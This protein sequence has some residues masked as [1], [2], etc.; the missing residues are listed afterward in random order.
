[1]NKL[2]HSMRIMVETAIEKVGIQ[3][4][5][6]YRYS[7]YVI[8]ALTLSINL[9]LF[10]QVQEFVK[11]IEASHSLYGFREDTVPSLL[12]KLLPPPQHK[13]EAQYYVPPP[14]DTKVSILNTMLENL[15][16]IFGFHIPQVSNRSSHEYTALCP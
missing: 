11:V 5:F 3:A 16:W 4:M 2:P 8:A 14:L 9:G 10:S 12:L 6:H 7:Q 1:M 15:K 13:I